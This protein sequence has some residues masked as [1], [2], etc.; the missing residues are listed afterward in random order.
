M[1]NFYR[2]F[3][4]KGGQSHILRGSKGV[5]VTIES[6]GKVEISYINV[7]L[8]NAT[9]VIL[10][11]YCAEWQIENDCY[12]GGYY[13]LLSIYMYMVLF[14]QSGSYY[15]LY[16]WHG[17][18]FLSQMAEKGYMSISFRFGKLRFVSVNFVSFRF[19]FVSHFTGIRFK[20]LYSLK[21]IQN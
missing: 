11:L 21:I 9:S 13:N 12:V 10:Q 17:V 15:W 8:L 7:G 2:P 3:C 4:S 20:Y 16:V 1:L 18:I 14:W 19:D 6:N 5:G